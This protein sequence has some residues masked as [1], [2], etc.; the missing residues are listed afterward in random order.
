M[1]A[2]VSVFFLTRLEVY[3]FRAYLKSPTLH[4]C[5]NTWWVIILAEWLSTFP[6]TDVLRNLQLCFQVNCNKTSAQFLSQSVSRTS[7]PADHWVV[8]RWGG[9]DANRKWSTSLLVYDQRLSAGGWRRAPL[10]P[11][12]YCRSVGALWSAKLFSWDGSEATSSLINENIDLK[13]NIQTEKTPTVNW[14]HDKMENCSKL[15]WKPAE[16]IILIFFPTQNSVY[17]RTHAHKG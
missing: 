7:L 12:A 16:R 11:Y 14:V 2:F 8:T 5:K 4:L 9:E 15:F 3:T 1:Y 13:T 10:Q 6:I 17:V